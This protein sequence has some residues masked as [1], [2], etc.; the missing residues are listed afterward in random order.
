MA[1]SGSQSA[2]NE[3]AGKSCFDVIYNQPDPRPYF[4]RLAPLGYETPHHAQPFFRRIA[5]ERAAL[6]D[7]HPF[8]PAVLD[9][10]CS[11]GINAALLNHNVTLAQ[12]YQRYTSRTALAMT[13]AQLAAWDRE[14]YAKRRR[15]DALPVFGLDI[16][17]PA[18]LLNALGD[19]LRVV[20]QLEDD[21]VAGRHRAL[22]AD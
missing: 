5:A 13:T 3:A 19:H 10:C 1:G 16:A 6:S 14:F 20:G 22:A 15:P 8:P 11:Y 4:T 7:G 9:L 17:A 12:L 18:L 2:S 21:R